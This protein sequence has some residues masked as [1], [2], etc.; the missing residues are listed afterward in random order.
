MGI[1]IKFSMFLSW[2]IW[3][4]R[5]RNF[6]FRTKEFSDHAILVR[7]FFP[8][9]RKFVQFQPTY[10]TGHVFHSLDFKMNEANH[11]EKCLLSNTTT[12]INAKCK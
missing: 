10:I 6:F 5:K 8:M 2:K 9:R 11:K 4:K 7:Q 1:S 12:K 3:Q